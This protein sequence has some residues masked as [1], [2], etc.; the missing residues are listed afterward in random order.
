MFSASLKSAISQSN[1]LLGVF[2]IIEVARGS[3]FGVFSV[4]LD[5]LFGGLEGSCPGMLAALIPDSL[6]KRVGIS[7]LRELVAVHFTLMHN[8]FAALAKVKFQGIVLVMR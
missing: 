7:E 3:L 8:A 4:C 1:S 2:R 6:K 5:C